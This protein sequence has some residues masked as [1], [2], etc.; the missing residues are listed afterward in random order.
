MDPWDPAASDLAVISHAHADHA[1]PGGSAYLAAREGA[2]VL[3]RRLGEEAPLETLGWGEAVDLGD[4]RVSLHPAGHVLGSAQVRIE[5]RRSGEVWVVSGDFKVEP[6]PTCT[7]F[8]P[9]SCHGLVTESTFGLPVFRWPD[10]A[11]VS[12]AIAAW[13]RSNREE[14]RASVLFAYAV[15]K[16]QRVLAGLLPHLGDPEGPDRPGPIYTHGAVEAMVRRY[17]E[18]GVELPATRP[19]GLVEEEAAGAGAGRS[20]VDWSRALVVA[21]PSAAGSPWM[22]RFGRVSTAFASGWMRLRGTR[23]R[24]AV[25]RG[26][27]LSDH[28][29]WPGLLSAIEATGAETVWVTHGYRDALARYLRE[30]RGLDARAVESRFEGET[31]RAD[32]EDAEPEDAG[33]EGE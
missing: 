27:V 13:W 32:G 5:H 33:G 3:R 24:R 8:E 10:P 17:R 25:D 28:A 18:A 29:D 11:Q 20:R 12:A 30:E 22:R 31:D 19:V 14:G 16:A 15:G 9:V 26:F 6:D 1:R 7:P 4:T 2:P 21:P 23:R